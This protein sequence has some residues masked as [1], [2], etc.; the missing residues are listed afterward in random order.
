MGFPAKLCKKRPNAS[1]QES[2][3]KDLSGNTFRLNDFK[4][5]VVV[6]EFMATWCDACVLQMPEL[7]IIWEKYGS[8]IV[9][10]SVD[11]DYMESEETLRSFTKEFPYATWLWTKNKANLDEY[12]DVKLVPKTVLIG[13]DGH[14]RFVHEGTVSSA[15]LIEEINQLLNESILH[16][17][18]VDA[19]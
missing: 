9:L 1:V 2:S 4:G 11:V 3:F 15:I 6:L 16:D 5:R 8:K 10:I 7:K 14:T 19:S 12:Y 18:D 17:A 13:K